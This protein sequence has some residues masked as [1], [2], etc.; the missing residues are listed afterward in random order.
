MSGMGKYTITFDVDAEMYLA[1]QKA[2]R[3]LGPSMS[4]TIRSMVHNYLRVHPEIVEPINLV[5]E[6][7][8]FKVGK[9]GD[10][11]KVG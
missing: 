2:T 4:A 11:Y 1:L 10:W 5:K 3:R 9:G 8:K 7:G 6:S